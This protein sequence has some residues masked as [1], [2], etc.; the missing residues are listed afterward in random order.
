MKQWFDD[1][2]TR[3]RNL[4]RKYCLA[5]MLR[6]RGGYEQCFW[7]WKHIVLKFGWV[8]IFPA[9]LIMLRRLIYVTH[10]FNTRIM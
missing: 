2:R 8:D 4:L 7:R 3:K 6:T 10:Q 1:E 9:H 5:W